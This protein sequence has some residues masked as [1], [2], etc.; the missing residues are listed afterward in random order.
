M[1]AEHLHRPLWNMPEPGTAAC[2]QPA[3]QHPNVPIKAAEG[4]LDRKSEAIGADGAAMPSG[5]QK[6]SELSDN[7]HDKKTEASAPRDRVWKLPLF[8]KIATF[9][10]K[11]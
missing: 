10:E 2:T 11:S 6:E 5:P 3:P 1:D 7:R 8:T 9:F 4:I